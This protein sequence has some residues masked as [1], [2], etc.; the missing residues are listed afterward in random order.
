MNGEQFERLRSAVQW[1]VDNAAY[2]RGLAEA[3]PERAHNQEVWAE[4]KVLEERAP[5]PSAFHM[6]MGNVVPLSQSG[7][8]MSEHVSVVCPSALCLAGDVVLEAGGTFVVDE[9]LRVGSAVIVDD[10]IMPDGRFGRVVAFA[11]DLLGLDLDEGADLFDSDN[12]IG[13]I[14]YFATRSAAESG[15]DLIAALR[16]PEGLL[17]A[18]EL[19]YVMTY[20]PAGA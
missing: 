16:I 8:G 20:A 18:D 11:R 9:S 15:H 10:A 7:Y 1:A 5:L 4:G 6:T 19:D 12:R 17:S 14:L 13:D 2:E 3:Q